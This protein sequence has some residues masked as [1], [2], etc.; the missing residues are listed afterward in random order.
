MR[1]RLLASSLRV[2]CLGA[3]VWLLVPATHPAVVAAQTS[4]YGVNIPAAHPR[5]R[6]GE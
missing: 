5:P 4:A 3:A 6:D 1:T 2:L